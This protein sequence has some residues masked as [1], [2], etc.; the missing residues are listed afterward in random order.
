MVGFRPYTEDGKPIIDEAP[1]IKGFF[2]VAGHEGDGIVLSPI[3]GLL[4][5]NFIEN[6]G[7]YLHFAERLGLER[8]STKEN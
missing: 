2:I 1:D 4:A 5:A 6:D 3:T 8:F 7:S